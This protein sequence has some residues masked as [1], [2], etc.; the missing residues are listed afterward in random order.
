[1]Q[2]R[3]EKWMPNSAHSSPSFPF[4]SYFMT[5][6]EQ[7]MPLAS[8][9]TRKRVNK[10][11]VCS[12]WLF[13]DALPAACCY[14]CNG[15]DKGCKNPRRQIVKAFK[16]RT[17][18]PNICASSVWNLVHVS[19]LGPRALGWPLNFEKCEGLYYIFVFRRRQVVISS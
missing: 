18:A 9:E 17:I 15:L 5:R 6:Y 12:S 4:L 19:L 8:S 3:R 13:N 11:S 10:S 1:M 14:I 2:S 7:P 16:F